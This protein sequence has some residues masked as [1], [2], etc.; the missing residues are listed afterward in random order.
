MSKFNPLCTILV[1]VVEGRY[2]P[3]NPTAKVFVECRFT[4]EILSTISPDSNSILRTDAVEQI[5]FPIWDTELAWEVDQKTLHN[6]RSQWA[7]L[8][9]QCFSV[10]NGNKN[11]LFGYAMLDIRAAADRPGKDFWVSL[12]NNNTRTRG[13]RP[14]INISFC[15]LANLSPPVTPGGYIPSPLGKFVEY[16]LPEEGSEESKQSGKLKE[17][18]YYRIGNDGFDRLLFSVTINFGANLQMLFQESYSDS[19]AHHSSEDLDELDM[20]IVSHGY[21]FQYTFLDSIV[22]S[23]RFY[24]LAHPNIKPESMSFRIESS[25]K[26]FIEFLN[27]ESK[28]VINLY[29]DTQV[30]GYAEIPLT[31]LFQTAE[32]RSLDIVCPIYNSKGELP[33]SA[34]MQT[35]RIGVFLIIQREEDAIYYIDDAPDSESSVENNNYNNNNISSQFREQNSEHEYRILIE[36][37]SIKLNKPIP[38]IYIRYSY[39]ALGIT[40]YKSTQTLKSIEAGADAPLSSGMNT[41]DVKMTPQRFARYFEAVPLLMEL[42]QRGE[43]K[44]SELGVASLHLAEVFLSNPTRDDNIKADI[45]N[46]TTLTPIKSAG[47][48]IPPEMGSIIA[49]I[50]V[51]DFG[52]NSNA[53]SN[54]DDDD[55]NMS[56]I[57]IADEHSLMNDTTKQS[58]NTGNVDIL[59]GK[60]SSSNVVVE[61]DQ[62]ISKSSSRFRTEIFQRAA[63]HAKFT[64]ETLYPKKEGKR[65]NNHHYH[66]NYIRNKIQQL[67]SVDVQLQNSIL[68]FQTRDE[69]LVRAEKDLE[70]RWL[71]L[72]RQFEQRTRD[73]KVQSEADLLQKF[74]FLRERTPTAEDTI[75]KLRLENDSLRAQLEVSERAK[76]EYKSQ[77][78]KSLQDDFPRF[79]WQMQRMAEEELESLDYEKLSLQ[80]L[81]QELELL[82]AE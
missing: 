82:R 26:E 20:T 68:C 2:F 36:L 79:W 34:D 56:E 45:V 16:S 18:G 21:Y 29:H 38:N 31:G 46:F 41:I 32:P 66:P 55:N 24:D 23:S 65:H 77:W 30:I 3:Q 37:I 47:M 14:E 70:R 54:E 64:Q 6:L 13:P 51:E 62:N 35:A 78:S 72:D 43:Q 39:P 25:L 1:T 81:K 69:S 76:S 63:E 27:Q 9:L 33:L 10:G 61:E 15:I 74:K 12:I 17:D 50:R 59:D 57:K 4:D 40:N 75:K 19:S 5:N 11:E 53:R 48:V 28:L 52:E 71:E 49:S 8:K 73:M 44:D 58:I 7:H 42:R 60:S 22:T 67:K 80:L